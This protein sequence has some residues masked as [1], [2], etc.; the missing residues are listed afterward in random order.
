MREGECDPIDSI[1]KCWE[2]IRKQGIGDALGNK[3]NRDIR[4]SHVIKN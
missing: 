1:N 2:C 4:V 3:F